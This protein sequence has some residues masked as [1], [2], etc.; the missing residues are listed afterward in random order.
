[1]SARCVGA[2]ALLAAL[3]GFAFCCWLVCGA[4]GFV[5]GGLGFSVVKTVYV[6]AGG[7]LGVRSGAVL[8]G[9]TCIC[10]DA[11]PANHWVKHMVCLVQVFL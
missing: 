1:M 2:C 11:A 5:F 6:A 8:T 9:H 10:H 7:G 4:W 3:M